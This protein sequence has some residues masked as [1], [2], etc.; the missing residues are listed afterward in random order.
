MVVKLRR[1]AF[2]IMALL[3]ALA[4]ILVW[5]LLLAADDIW[6]SLACS[7]RWSTGTNCGAD[8]TYATPL[9]AMLVFGVGGL[10]T[11][12]FAWLAWQ[13]TLVLRHGEPP[14]AS[15]SQTESRTDVLDPTGIQIVRGPHTPPP[16]SAPA[17]PPAPEN[18]QHQQEP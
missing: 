10:I 2:V 1:N 7:G 9:M 8:A 5:W 18:H 16:P 17:M 4:T 12:S 11:A 15:R 13:E 14:S 6:A 3:S